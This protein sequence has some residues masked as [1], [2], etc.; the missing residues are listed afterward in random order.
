M[1]ITGI[2]GNIPHQGIKERNPPDLH[3]SKPRS[4]TT[5]DNGSQF[6]I[7]DIWIDT[8]SKDSFILVSKAKKVSTWLP[9]G[10]K[11]DDEGSWTPQ[12]QFSGANVGM[13]GTFSGSYIRSGNIVNV[14]FNIDLTSKGS[15]T[16]DATIINLPFTSTKDTS[17]AI[18]RYDFLEDVGARDSVNG[19]VSNGSIHIILG[20]SGKNVLGVAIIADD[21][22][23]NTSIH[24]QFFYFS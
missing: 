2:P 20:N 6:F 9:F 3:I 11:T 18:N 16:G 10:T 23:D 14:I 21:F 19:S 24:G 5:S 8:K 22:A 13:T 7:G 1:P 12:L 15:S 17:F 4:P